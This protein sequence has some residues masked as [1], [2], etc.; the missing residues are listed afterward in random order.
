MRRYK[1]LTI[2][3]EPWAAAQVAWSSPAANRAIEA[4]A[5]ALQDADLSAIRREDWNLLAD[6][7]SGSAIAPHWTPA[8]LRAK[9]E[10]AMRRNQLDWKWYGGAEGAPP[11]RHHPRARRLLRILS[12]L[13]F[14][15]TQAILTAVARFWA[16]HREIDPGNDERWAAATRIP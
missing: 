16:N 15:Q 12:D 2:Y 9:I 3:P 5:R 13:S 10:D 4:W 14:I 8:M 7:L 6:A 1:Q 11:N